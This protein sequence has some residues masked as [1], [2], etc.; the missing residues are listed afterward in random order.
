MSVIPKQEMSSYT[1]SFPGSLLLALRRAGRREPWERGW[2]LHSFYIQK[3]IGEG[4]VHLIIIIIIII[5]IFGNN[6]NN[7]KQA[8]INVKSRCFGIIM[9]PFSRQNE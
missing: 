6:N 5:I 1:T 2:K 9:T 8:N 3:K 7:N 4:M